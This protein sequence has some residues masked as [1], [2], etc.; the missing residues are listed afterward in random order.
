M[1][2]NA[3]PIRVVIVD[4]HS[5][6]REGTRQILLQDPAIEVIAE[7]GRG[8]E[9]VRLAAELKP[10]VLLLDLRLPGLPGIDAAR[11]V[12]TESPRTRVLVLT[13]YDEE[14]YVLE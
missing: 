13:A 14:D 1:V 6:L 12:A 10:D 4:D 8:D 3:A 2:E 5:L 9:A 7:S 11:R